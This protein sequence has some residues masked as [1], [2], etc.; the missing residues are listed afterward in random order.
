MTSLTLFMAPFAFLL[1]DGLGTSVEIVSTHYADFRAFGRVECISDPCPGGEVVLI[2]RDTGL[3]SRASYYKK[4]IYRGQVLLGVDFER[5]FDYHW[6]SVT[7]EGH[8]LGEGEFEVEML[9]DNREISRLGFRLSELDFT[10][11]EFLVDLGLVRIIM[12]DSQHP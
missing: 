11:G 10:E 2:V 5:R 6:S 3:D 9:L 8:L 7:G 12:N 4:E 1:A